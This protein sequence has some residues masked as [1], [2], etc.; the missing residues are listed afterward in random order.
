MSRNRL[1]N[2]ATSPKVVKGAE[3]DIASGET[4]LV[5]KPASVAQHRTRTH[6]PGE[7]QVEILI[8]GASHLAGS[9]VLSA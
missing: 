6:Y 5:R 3:L 9:F 2:G 4:G 1:W 7:H 8:N